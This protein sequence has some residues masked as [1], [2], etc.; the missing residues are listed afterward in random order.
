MQQE[1]KYDFIVIGSGI[2]GLNT[3]LTLSP[4]GTI[5]IITKK[6]LHNSSTY[7]AQG[8][9]AAVIKH[10][11]TI[12]S[13][14]NDTLEAG[15]HHNKKEAVSLLV[16]GS[17]DAI[18]KLVKLG[19]LF[20][21]EKNGKFVT[22][23]EA[24]HS[25]PRILHATD[26]TGREIEKTLIKQVAK[27]PAITIWEDTAAVELIVKEKQCYGVQVIKENSFIN[28]FARAVV[29]ATG[30]TG[31]LYQWTT[32]P[33]VST[34]DGIALAA[35]MGA[36]VRDLEFVQFH[37]TALQENASP[38]LLL[39]EAL[40]G[41]GAILINAKGER[42]MKK[43]H[44]LAELAPRDVVARAIFQEQKTGT[45]FIDISNKKKAFILKRFPNIAR[46]LKTRGF[47]ITREPIPVTPA[48]HFMCGGIVTDLSGRTSIK[49]LF[50]Y[51]EVAATGIHGANRLASNS[52]LEGMVF[53]NKIKQ[54]IHELPKTSQKIQ[55]LLPSL[56]SIT[57]EN[58]NNQ[59]R[60]IMWE[61]VGIIRTKK[62]L[63][64]AKKKLQLLR[65]K[66]EEIKGTN[67]SLLETKNMLTVSLLIVAAA[68]KRTESLGTHY[69]QQ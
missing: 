34:G 22:S 43:V 21:K 67:A 47:D 46:A 28:L 58:V 19:V 10:N 20:D 11:D 12:D 65:K 45:V 7:H 66:L 52:L 29:L 59:I 38:L 24:A 42:F 14:I 53:S 15:Y 31:Q 6:K 9:I 8:G 18:A 27:N 23:Y 25:Y 57:A 69:L 13:H 55:T 33:S 1:K 37:P 16:N 61:Y 51:G 2:A 54:C 32:N 56:P 64:T 62:G 50:A 36:K 63:Q 35:R 40:R 39:S 68:Q 30:G 5:L 44:P 41:E 26:F 60:E 3:A 17:A 48:A 49:N 4:F